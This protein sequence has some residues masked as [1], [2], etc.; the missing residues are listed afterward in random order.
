MSSLLFTFPLFFLD[1]SISPSLP[2]IFFNCLPF[3]SHPL[4][5]PQER[6]RSALE[7]LNPDSQQVLPVSSSQPRGRMSAEEQL[8]RMKKHQRA[9]VRER[10]RNLSHGDRFSN[11]GAS[12][13]PAPPSSSVDLGPVCYHHPPPRNS[14]RH[15]DY[16]NCY[17]PEPP[18]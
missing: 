16:C 4:I 18:L 2:F 9:L 11:T 10:K 3:S 1:S 17:G 12:S 7:R 8:E 15:R 14:S 13:R 5:R 6:P